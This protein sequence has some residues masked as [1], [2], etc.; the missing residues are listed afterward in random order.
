MR[1]VLEKGLLLG[2]GLAVKSKEQI[3]MFVEDL[4]KKGEI[5]KEESNDLI[6]ELI[7]KGQQTQGQVDDMIKERMKIIL[8]D[9]NLA[10]KAEVDQLEKRV[11]Q[12]EQQKQE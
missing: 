8:N 10:T 2:I 9:L 12:L 1:N 6:S 5:K 3:E 4:V 11:R 7:Q